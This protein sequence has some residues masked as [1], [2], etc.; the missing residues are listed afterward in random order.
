[1]DGLETRTLELAEDKAHGNQ[2]LELAEDEVHANLMWDYIEGVQDLW[3]NSNHSPYE[4]K[5]CRALRSDHS[6]PPAVYDIESLT[7]RLSN[8]HSSPLLRCLSSTA[9]SPLNTIENSLPNPPLSPFLLFALSL[10]LVSLFTPCSISTSP[11][12]HSI[13]IPSTATTSHSTDSIS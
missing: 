3:N 9:P 1:M 2:N 7:F 6:L 12:S 13:D 10:F 8:K 4:Y 5:R 11:I